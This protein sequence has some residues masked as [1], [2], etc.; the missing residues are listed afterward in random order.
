M[1]RRQ[2]V[3][4]AACLAVPTY[5]HGIHGHGRHA[6]D[7]DDHHDQ[8]EPSLMFSRIRA[9]LWTTAVRVSALSHDEGHDHDRHDE[10][11]SHHEIIDLSASKYDQVVD[12]DVHVCTAMRVVLTRSL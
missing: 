4:V 8:C 1:A 11:H 5:G 3:A 10:L 6:H 7:D 2:H 12:N 9:R